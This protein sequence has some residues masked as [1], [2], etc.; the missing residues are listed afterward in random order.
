MRFSHGTEAP[1]TPAARNQAPR[2]HDEVIRLQ[3]ADGSWELSDELLR[4]VG[5][6]EREVGRLLADARTVATTASLRALATAI[7]LAWLR[8][9]AGAHE[10]EWRLVA[11]KAERWLASYEAT[12]GSVTWSEAVARL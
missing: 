11:E 12:P 10:D 6:S 5:I 8:R 4:L 3:R 9:Q 2:L 7:V 1:P